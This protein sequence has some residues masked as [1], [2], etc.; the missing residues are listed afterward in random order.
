MQCSSE[1][2]IAQIV[3]AQTANVLTKRVQANAWPRYDKKELEVLEI[4]CKHLD[5]FDCDRPFLGLLFVQETTANIRFTF[6][7]KYHYKNLVVL[8]FGPPS[9]LNIFSR[10]PHFKVFEKKGFWVVFYFSG[11]RFIL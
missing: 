10:L 2:S 7:Y 6:W 8:C 1:V 3:F 4:H 9:S 5:V 11:Y